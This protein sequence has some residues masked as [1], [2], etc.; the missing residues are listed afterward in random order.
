LYLLIIITKE[1][2]WPV[3]KKREYEWTFYKKNKN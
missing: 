3:K 2:E 1:Y